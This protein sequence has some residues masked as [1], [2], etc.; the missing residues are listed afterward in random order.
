MLFPHPPLSNGIHDKE[1]ITIVG[2]NPP[3]HYPLDI[4][5]PGTGTPSDI[6]PSDIFPPPPRLGHYPPWFRLV[7]SS[8]IKLRL[9]GVKVCPESVRRETR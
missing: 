2:H 1:D 4:I 7:Q 3:G 5:P 9:L 8:V 6:S